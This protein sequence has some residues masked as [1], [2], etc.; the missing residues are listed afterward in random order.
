MFSDVAKCN[1]TCPKSDTCGHAKSQAELVYDF[2]Q[3]CKG[4]SMYFEHYENGYRDSVIEEVIPI[5]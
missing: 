2:R 1:K 3:I 5:E 4:E